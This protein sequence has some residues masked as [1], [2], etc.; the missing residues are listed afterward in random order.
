MVLSAAPMMDYFNELTNDLASVDERIAAKE[1]LLLCKKVQLDIHRRE[2]R[3]IELDEKII[4][5]EIAL[6]VDIKELKNSLNGLKIRHFHKKTNDCWEGYFC[7][8]LIRRDG[9]VPY[10]SPTNF[11]KEHLKA[12]KKHYSIDAYKECEILVNS[13]WISLREYKAKFCEM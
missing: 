13:N 11:V 8:N 12:V 4:R 7:G 2:K 10:S 1:M 5:L 3:E 9:A 6:R